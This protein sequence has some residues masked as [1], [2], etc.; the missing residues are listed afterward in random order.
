VVEGFAAEPTPPN[1]ANDDSAT[2]E[3]GGRA[4]TSN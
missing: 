4:G 1:T 2:N 3:A